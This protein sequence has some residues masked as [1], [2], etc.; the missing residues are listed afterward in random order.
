MEK[1]TV[2][3]KVIDTKV[4]KRLFT[5]I[6]PYKKKFYFLVFLTVSLAFI[7][8][9]R[10]I[11]IQYIL[12]VP[13]VKGDYEELLIVTIF[14]IFLL[15]VSTI[16][17]YYHTYISGWIGQSII[18]DMRMKVFYHLQTFRLKFFDK[19]PIGRIVTRNVSDV[20]TLSDV[21]SEG[22]AAIVG[23][24]LQIIV[25]LIIMFVI[26]WKMTLV[27]LSLFPLMILSTYIF[28]EKVKKSFNEVRTA[29]ANL[30]SFVQEHITG[31]GIVQIFNS[32]ARE[33][34]KFQ[35]I[36]G[37]HKRANI[38]SVL[39]YSIYFPVAEVIQAMGIGLIVW[40]GARNVIDNE[41]TIGVLI[42]FIM[43][44][45]MFFRPVR[46]IADR[47]NTLQMGIVSTKRILDLIDNKEDVMDNGTEDI[48]NIRG[49]I[50][51]RNVSF[52]YN[53]DEYVL[54]DI[55]IQ[56][57]SGETIAI[58]GATG[59]G[60]SSI[61]NLLNRF[62]EINKGT[63]FLD[64]KDIRNYKLESLRRHIGLVLQDV[65]LFSGS[66]Y[67]NIT[68]GDKSIK[69]EEVWEACELVG[70]SEFI[71]KLPGGLDY[72]VMERGVTLSVG[73]RQ[74]ISF[75][76]AL[77]YNPQIIIL[78]EATSSIDTETEQLIQ[79]AIFKLMKGRTAIV[80]AHRLSTIQNAHKI[81][82]L[83]KGCIKEEGTHESLMKQEG[84]YQHLYKLNIKV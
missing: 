63:I 38:K 43:Y 49:I 45:Q 66:I 69:R 10:P 52:A 21:F 39:Y 51:F 70:A 84:Y 60:K 12:D 73:Q 75:V 46:M 3:G 13:L 35:K 33:F 41:L 6:K 42:S 5:F 31:M 32:E 58:V 59:A 1:E 34:H 78:D 83:D 55:N 37:E 23:D 47:F 74:L 4:L 19:T 68:L 79:N 64:G 22:I 17:Q 29:V 62:Y 15:I 72:D 16:M 77:V 7:V 56:I 36:N 20:E 71:E 24:L 57:K 2:S 61:I 50:E 27:C 25:I 28:K 26:S 53:N 9:V 76:R 11:I 8:P 14:L 80:I 65:F 18:H 40:Y 67:Y 44:I 54:K 30:N 81:I 48:Q 82:V